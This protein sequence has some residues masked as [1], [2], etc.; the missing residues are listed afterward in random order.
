MASAKV[1]VHKIQVHLFLQTFYFLEESDCLSGDTVIVLS[2]SQVQSFDQTG[3]DE[4]YINIFPENVLLDDLFQP[5]SCLILMIW[6]YL[7][8]FSGANLSLR[9]TGGL[10]L[11]NS[12]GIKLST[13]QSL[14]SKLGGLPSKGISLNNLL[15]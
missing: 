3:R 2:Q 8:L 12:G 4:L 13:C 15:Y 11:L 1:V 7:N 14:T 10:K 5:S 6:A 9:V